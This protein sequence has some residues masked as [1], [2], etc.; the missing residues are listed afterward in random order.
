MLTVTASGKL[1]PVQIIY[2]GKTLACIPK[3]TIPSDWHVT[4]T[5]NH[6]ANEGTVLGNIYN[7]ILPYIVDTHKELINKFLSYFQL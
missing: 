7:I 4:Y 5:A 6:W 1:L 2:E 3:I